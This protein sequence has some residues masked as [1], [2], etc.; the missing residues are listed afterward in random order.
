MCNIVICFEFQS[1][2]TPRFCATH[3]YIAILSF[4]GY[5][6]ILLE[7]QYCSQPVPPAPREGEDNCFTAEG[8][9]GKGERE[10]DAPGG[11]HRTKKV[12]HQQPH[13]CVAP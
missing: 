11:A 6:N 7:R 12:S 13:I 4:L 9:G 5:G 1:F 3:V 8:P 2:L 10:A